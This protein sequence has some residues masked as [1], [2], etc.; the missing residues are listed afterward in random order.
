MPK[1]GKTTGLDARPLR[2]LALAA[3]ALLSVVIGLL[4]TDVRRKLDE[5]ASSPAD[6]MQWTLSQL[7]VE[8]L[9]FSMVLNLATQPAASPD[10]SGLRKRYDILYSR[11]DTLANSPIYHPAMTAPAMQGRFEQA[12]QTIIGLAPLIDGN[13]ADLR[14]ALTPIKA[15]VDK[16]RQEIRAI[17]TLG[18][19]ILV[20]HSDA[21][22]ADV[23]RVLFRL[24]IASLVLIGALSLFVVIFRQL[25][26][27]NQ[28]RA[29]EIQRT[30]AR[31]ATIVA[32]SRD[33]ILV[34]DR[35]GRIETA[36]A[37]A[38]T[39][40]ETVLTGARISTILSQSCAA[41]ARPVRAEDLRALTALADKTGHRL[42]G[43]R[44]DATCF[45]VELSLGITDREGAE[46]IVC[47][48]RDIS[49]QVAAEEELK[50]SR[51]RAL[52]GERVKAR[53]LGV[54]SH[55]M[56]TPLNGIIG[57]IEL[58]DDETDQTEIHQRLLPI[59]RNSAQILLDL[60]NDVLDITRIEGSGAANPAPFDLAALLQSVIDSERPHARA[61]GNRLTLETGAEIGW[62]T[63]DAQRLR[64]ILLNL[65]S[66]AIKFTEMGRITLTVER[67]DGDLVE[68]RVADTGIGIDPAELGSIFDDFVRTE[69]AQHRQIQ[70]TGLGLGIA[71][72]LARAMGGEVEAESTQGKGSLFRVTLPLPRTEPQRQ[73][74][75]ESAA[76]GLQAPSD[77]APL[78]IAVAQ[79]NILLVEDNAANRFVAR[80]MLERHG[81]HPH[82]A[83]NGAEAVA[84]A[85]RQRFD[86]ILMDISM[87]VMDGIE[88]ARRIRTGPGE[89]RHTRIVALTAHI[90]EDIAAA[91]RDAGIDAM[92]A[93]PLT[94][95]DLSRVLSET[96]AMRPAPEGGDLS[97]DIDL[98]DPSRIRALV[99]AA[100]AAK[101]EALLS[102]FVD[103]GDRLFPESGHHVTGMQTATAASLHRLAGSAA[104]LGA[105]R[106]NAALTVL[107]TTAGSM[108]PAALQQRLR[109]LAPVWVQTRRALAAQRPVTPPGRPYRSDAGRGLGGD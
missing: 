89:N 26:T 2:M 104:V 4:L 57:T 44:R 106:L 68:L 77:P 23:A 52:A 86:L 7:E 70:G 92:A 51:D 82:E 73:T 83:V 24:A 99:R 43:K 91:L 35:H 31:L 25:A 6:N 15:E 32:T 14:A 19:Q 5:L 105:G 36:N 103:E 17:L 85:S 81:H 50:I 97:A 93:K 96:L 62:V 72:Q 100:G 20:E 27:S 22:R 41:G 8:F 42:I 53:F 49:H 59:L 95:A 18:N 76:R 75:T 30:S 34:L 45:P 33:A 46:V 1:D 54:I 84:L 29:G 107:E 16:M 80:R 10:L 55:E 108:E 74:D 65:V 64:Q 37:A 94:S 71:R 69:A 79:L 39:M 88:A 63:G 28:R 90:G 13:D 102:T 40:F 21:A 101:A 9:E 56:R 48:I 66:N 3:L 98:L 67:V 47:V 109:S 61:G 78:H 60:V 38:E 58:I 12:A 11:L 87:P